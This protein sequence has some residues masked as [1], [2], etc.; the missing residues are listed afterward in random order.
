MPILS[1][2]A[3]ELLNK[4]FGA[5]NYTPP[6]TWY[7]GLRSGGTELSGSG[8][9]RV[10]KTNNTTNW[11][12]V[13]ANIM[14]NGTAITFP[15]ASSDWATA[16]EV[17]LFIAGSGGTAKYTGVLDSPVTVRSGQTRQFAAG[18]LRIKFV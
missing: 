11:P 9:G 16:D 6:A 3:A 18:D 13:A 2:H 8:Y 12:N 1:T 5:T 4:D 17:C 15:T 10:A 7:I 14:V